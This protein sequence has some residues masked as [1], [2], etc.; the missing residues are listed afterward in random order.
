VVTTDGLTLAGA[1][2]GSDPGSNTIIKSPVSLTYFFDSGSADNYPVI[3]IDGVTGATV[4]DLRVDGAGRGNGN[5]RFCGIAFWNAGGTVTD[6]YVVD[7]RETPFS[8]NQHGVGIYSN[9]DAGGPYTINVSGTTVEGF[10]KTGIA[11]NGSNLT[12]NVSGCTATG[13]GA[14]SVTAQN[15]IQI[16]WGPTG[17]ITDCS[18]SNIAYTGSYW[19]ASGMLIIHGGT[20]DISGSCTATDCQ[21]SVCF[22]EA[23]GSVDGITIT[24]GGVVS[25]E[26]ISVRDWGA[27]LGA[28]GEMEPVPASPLME[29]A[30]GEAPLGAT[31]TYVDISNATVTGVHYAGSY[32][33]AVWSLGDNV[34]S[35]ITGCSVNDWEIGVV[36]YEDGS[37]ANCD[38]TTNTIYGNDLGLWDNSSSLIAYSNQFYGNG[39][40]A[41]DDGASA[42]QWNS[43]SCPGNYW[44]DYLSNSGYSGGQ[45]YVPGTAGSVDD[46]PLSVGV[47]LEPATHL[48]AC[49]ETVTYEVAVDGNA[50]DL[51]GADYKINYDDAKLDFVSATAGALIATGTGEYIFAYQ[52]TPGQLLINSAHLNSGVNGPGVIAEVTFE[53][54]GSTSPGT[55]SLTFSD[56]DLRDSGNQTIPSA[57]TGADV[58]IDCEDPTIDVTLDPPESPWTCYN[59][60]PT[61]D[62]TAGDDYGLD[63][64]SYKINDGSWM[65]LECDLSGTSYSKVDWT[66]PEFA[67]LSEGTN[68][69]YFKSSD[70]AGNESDAVSVMFTKDTEAPSAVTD[71]TATVGHN[72]IELTWTNPG[73]D[74]DRVY[75]YRS[76]WTDYPEYGT[77]DPGY[78]SAGGSETDVGVL[79]TYTD[80]FSNTERGIYAY[81]AVV[82]DCAGNHAAEGSGDHDRATSYYLGDIAGSGGSGDYDGL[83]S[84][85]DYNPFSGCYWSVDPAGVCAEAD[86]A[87]T[88]EPV[89]GGLGIP[90]PDGYVG[91]EDLMIFA[92][93]YGNVPPA[94]GG[95]GVMGVELARLGMAADAS[96]YRLSLVEVS[97]EDGVVEMALVVEGNDLFK[98]LSVDVEYDH[99]GLEFVSVEPSEGLTG[100]SRVMFMGGE[101][102][103]VVKVDLAALGAGVGIGGDGPVAVLRFT[104]RGAEAT[105]VGIGQAEA[106][107]V[108]NRVLL[109][110][111]NEGVRVDAALPEEFALR[112]N[113]PNPFASTTQIGYDVPRAAQVGL[114]IYNIQGQMVRTLVDGPVPAGRHSE[115]W[116][117]LDGRGHAVPRGVYFL[118][119]S[120][121]GNAH[122][123]KLVK[124]H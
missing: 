90:V 82:Y 108:D 121:D 65:D 24:T 63:C 105:E 106:R 124:L 29:V 88:I 116:D 32:G 96:G 111:V 70:D 9:N 86:F 84:G 103:G 12:A 3:G 35:T 102:G 21:V 15:G 110:S 101:V 98:G 23:N 38:V 27:L 28:G 100:G 57:W 6:C 54:I 53:A 18:V 85:Y 107:D 112:G 39:A 44:D 109:L 55:T 58:V 78:P 5:V 45:Y 93:N 31:E 99:E 1:G 22:E 120:A 95:G 122:M 11:L 19:I 114:R 75:L 56:T 104:R 92:I 71:F 91:F 115:T 46:C 72:Q 118:K 123:M 59:E 30:H 37:V 97:D 33:I 25:E 83:V 60:A 2:S 7:V 26:G 74:L 61:V 36:A 13:Y 79:E 119:M 52:D 42:N 16:G 34:N 64:V 8:G 47:T 81:R 73:S 43:G 67:G 17:T 41:E 49:G 76:D 14:T 40:N 4:Q 77:T 50:L 48:M 51:M 80:T 68:T 113:S 87:P 69:Y 62:I 94:P 20:T 10:Q 89:R 117:G 66:L